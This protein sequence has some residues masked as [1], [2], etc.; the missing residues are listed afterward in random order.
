M[1]IALAS[2]LAAAASLLAAGL[3]HAASPTMRVEE[4]PLHGVRSLAGARAGGS[5]D[6]VGLHW[7]GV[8]SVSFRTASSRGRWS[9]WRP[10]APESEDLPDVASPEA[11]R[12]GGWRLG[13]PYWTGRSTRIEYRVRGRVS[14]LRAYLISSAA[15]RVPSR[16]LS[17]AG[18]PP[19]VSRLGWGANERIRRASPLFADAVRAA[20][21]HHTAGSN[22]YGP[23]ESAAIVRA[24]ELYHVQG[25]GWND[26]GYNFLVD[27][28]GQVFE[29]RFG[30][31]TRNVVG[32]HAEGFNTG[33]VGVAVLGSYGATGISPAARAAIAKVIAWRLDLAHVNPLL[34]LAFL[35]R[36]NP[37]FPAGALVFLRAV[38]G[39]RD[40]GFTTCPGDALYAQLPDLARAA[41]ST[42]LPKLYAPLVRGMVGGPVRFVARLSSALSWTV[43]ITTEAGA[44]VTA[45]SGTGT[46]I[47]WTW[48]SAGA[49]GGRYRYTISAGGARPVSGTVAGA[50]KP[51]PAPPPPPPP[52]PPTPPKPP[53]PQPALSLTG[54]L[55][56]PG[57][58]TP[59]GDGLNDSAL[60][61]Y[62]LTLP[63]TV[64]AT[65]VDA[66]GVVLST[67][68][69]EEK[70][71]GQS[72]FTFTADGVADGIYTIV[73]AARSPDGTEVTASV[74]V[75]VS[76]T[77]RTF[78]IEP[79]LFS[80][81][82]DGRRDAVIFTVS[83]AHEADVSVGLLRLG[84]PVA[85]AFAGAL[86]AGVR[87]IRWGQPLADGTYRV[88]VTASDQVGRVS[89]SRPL[90]VDTVAPRL[91]LVTVAPLRIGVS[92]P[93]V[94]SAVVNGKR[95]TRTPRGRLVR[96]D[97]VRHARTLRVVAR[98]AAGNRSAPLVFP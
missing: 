86:P 24:I 45:G 59:N 21:V 77:L 74:A 17:L 38:A 32:A 33:T 29:G 85:T 73:L 65:L 13:N 49:P 61:T 93:A 16:T 50:G 4:V 26:I 12:S 94:L 47:D 23:A 18:S 81:N 64:T 31:V 51:P 83:L 87:R 39:H 68:F 28:Y 30:G 79:A 43:A 58:I 84:R 60:V 35:S 36:G 25:N 14:R 96:L 95:A 37:R 46:S 8:G 75:L 80:P 42:G 19:I 56:T 98:D 72:S 5:F 88:L 76:R 67:L 7:R 20:I 63:A 91:R 62:T 48:R 11:A 92:E 41:A 90:R 89:L 54:L 71:L 69:S 52:P 78:G 97:V 3:A 40:T 53:P 15:E 2:A 70:P 6:V 66:S 57:T 10:A 34:P 55:A 1:K 82:A 27:K 44:P 9:R 22:A